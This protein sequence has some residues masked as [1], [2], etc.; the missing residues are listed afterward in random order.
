MRL[1]PRADSSV[2]LHHFRC[3]VSQNYHFFFT[4]YNKIFKSAY[5]FICLFLFFVRNIRTGWRHFAAVQIPSLTSPRTR[6]FVDG[7]FVGEI[8][9]VSAEAMFAVGNYQDGRQLFADAVDEVFLYARALS[10]A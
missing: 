7:A 8:A 2:D 1:L 3:D 9:A 10:G 4:H 6:M 5:L